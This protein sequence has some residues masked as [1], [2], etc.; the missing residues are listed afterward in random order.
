MDKNKNLIARRKIY[1]FSTVITLNTSHGDVLLTD[2]IIS[3]T[4]P[5]VGHF[6]SKT[7]GHKPVLVEECTYAVYTNGNNIIVEARDNVD[8]AI[9][10]SLLMEINR[11]M[12]GHY[13]L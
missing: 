13:K 3:P 1:G 2:G 7:K 8:S 12:T 4:S 5:A 9:I 6:S 11:K 10:D